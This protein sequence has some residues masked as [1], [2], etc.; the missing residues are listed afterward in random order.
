M[1][2]LVASHAAFN[3]KLSAATEAGAEKQRVAGTEA[4][5]ESEA[6]AKKV[7]AARERLARSAA[8]AGVPPPEDDVDW[9]AVN[10]EL[11][12]GIQTIEPCSGRPARRNTH[13]SIFMS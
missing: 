2:A 3:A 9:V 12:K 13:E 1:D 11:A 6:I 10:R 7:A 8:E 5:V 4:V